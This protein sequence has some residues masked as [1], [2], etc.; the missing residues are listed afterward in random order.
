VTLL[1]NPAALHPETTQSKTSVEFA[2][3]QYMTRV[4]PLARKNRLRSGEKSEVVNFS[5]SGNG[6]CLD[7]RCD[8]RKFAILR[9]SKTQ[10][11]ERDKLYYELRVIH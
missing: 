7:N 2:I 6:N 11:S 9:L 4:F 1:H 8:W 10:N 3:D 5:G